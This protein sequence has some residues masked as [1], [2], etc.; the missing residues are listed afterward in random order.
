MQILV[1]PDNLEHWNQTLE[2]GARVGWPQSTMDE[3]PGLDQDV[4]VD[5]PR[6]GR[7]A[8]ENGCRLGVVGVLS[9]DQRV[10]RRRVYER[11]QSR[12]ASSR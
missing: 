5:E 8:S 11:R 2:Q 12:N 1:D 7:E 6:S 10:E 4:V 9:V 3:R